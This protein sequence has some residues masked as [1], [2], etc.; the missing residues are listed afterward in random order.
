MRRTIDEPEVLGFV[1]CLR[2]VTEKRGNVADAGAGYDLDVLPRF[3]DG[4]NGVWSLP[5]FDELG[6]DP[7][8]L[9]YPLGFRLGERTTQADDVRMR[10]IA[11]F[12]NA[13]LLMRAHLDL[14]LDIFF[15]HCTSVG[16]WR[17]RVRVMV[18]RVADD[19]PRTSKREQKQCRFRGA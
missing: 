1:D 8:P 7:D 19:D 10:W 13:A 5:G 12:A 11:A 9:L 16:P 15:G 17:S 2:R 4:D 3:I 6:E 18:G 14:G